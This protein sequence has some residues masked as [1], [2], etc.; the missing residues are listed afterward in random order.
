L[1][2]VT[3]RILAGNGYEVISAVNGG[4]AVEVAACRE[5]AAQR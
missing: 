2:E 4:D 1:R 5:D 3:R